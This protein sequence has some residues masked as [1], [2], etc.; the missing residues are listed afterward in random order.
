V[1]D[2][3]TIQGCSATPG[4]QIGAFSA[5]AFGT[6]GNAGRDIIHG[7]GRNNF[8]LS[9]FKDTKLT[10]RTTL[11]LRLEVY[12]LFNHTQFNQIDNQSLGATNIAAMDTGDPG[13][14][15]DSSNFLHLTGAHAPRRMQ[16][17]LRFY[18]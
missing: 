9:L 18:F 11:E 12:N 16:F 10:E 15:L 5:P 1:P 17:G 6:E 8:D 13:A 14:N 4:C 2:P 7:P 3:N